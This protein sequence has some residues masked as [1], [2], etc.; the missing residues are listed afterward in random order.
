MGEV[1]SMFQKRQFTLSEAQEMLPLVR[2]ITRDAVESFLLLEAKIKQ[3][4]PESEAWKK[5]E[6]EIADLLQKWSEKIVKL[7]CD[8]KGIWLVD[9]DNGQ[10]YYCW[11]YDEELIE[12]QHSYEEG[13]HGRVKI[14]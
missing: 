3:C 1:I 8:A 12:Y 7:G 10:G 6:D 4:L 14:I 5:V 13:F 2:K 9:F 11:R